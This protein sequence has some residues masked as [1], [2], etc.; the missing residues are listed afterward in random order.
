M[1][2]SDHGDRQRQNRNERRAEVEKKDDDD[3][4]DDDGLFDQVALQRVDRIVESALNG[5]IRRRSRLP[6]A[7]RS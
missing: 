5:H 3:E 1:N 4:A 7:A 2:D 6:A